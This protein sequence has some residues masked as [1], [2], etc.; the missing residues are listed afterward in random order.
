MAQHPPAT[1][2]LAL[3]AAALAADARADDAPRVTRIAT[4]NVEDMKT[5]RIA[6]TDDRRLRSIAEHILRIR[7][8]ILLLNEIDYDQ[9]TSEGPGG[10]NAKRFADNFLTV[11]PVPNLPTKRYDAFM[12]PSNTGVHSGFDLDSDGSVVTEPGSN[13]YAVDCLGYGAYPGQ[14][15]MALL[16]GENYEIL[17][18]R[19]RTFRNLLWRDMPG[20]LLPPA[21]DDD[22]RPIPDSSWYSD[23]ELAVLPLSSKSHWDVPVRTPDGDVIHILAS[24]PTPPVFDGPED[25]NGRR[26]HDEIR[27]WRD[28]IDGADWI[29]DDAGRSGGLPEGAHFVIAG[30]LNSDPD[31][32]RDLDNPARRFLIEHPRV[33]DTEPR[34]KH[35]DRDNLPFD[36][37]DTAEFE[38]R[39]DY[40][41]PSTSLEAVRSGMIRAIIDHP[42]DK[43][44]ERDLLERAIRSVQP[45]PPS[46]HYP[47]W[48]DVRPARPAPGD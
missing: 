2:A 15:A 22:G 33:N 19:V 6:D 36:P 11:P 4:Y 37:T 20:A 18:D 30:D 23:D 28:Y 13:A 21:L 42:P 27:F 25:R 24:H 9:P 46:D 43:A 3:L 10:T 5:D 48:I 47:V 34:T 31:R 8:D 14:Y 35:P 44:G 12:A 1:L 41:L 7:P 39:V 45:R 38:L 40:V 26:N 17:E 29:V 32:G 16:V